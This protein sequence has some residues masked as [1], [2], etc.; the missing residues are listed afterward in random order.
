MRRLKSSVGVADRQTGQIAWSR[1]PAVFTYQGRLQGNIDVE[2][3]PELRL[4]ISALNFEPDVSR[5]FS[6]AEKQ[7]EYNITLKRASS[8]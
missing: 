1:D 2:D 8:P 4:R 5:V 6:A 7:V 3:R